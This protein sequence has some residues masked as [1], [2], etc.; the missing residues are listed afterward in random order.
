MPNGGA[1]EKELRVRLQCAHCM[2]LR[3]PAARYTIRARPSR[4]QVALQE[5]LFDEVKE[6]LNPKL[7]AEDINKKKVLFWQPTTTKT[8][9]GARSAPTHVTAW[10][11]CGPTC[12]TIS[13]S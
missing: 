13:P 2:M 1:D 8:K 9:G 7:P 10:P 12:T 5:A 4:V 11:R 3:E 6:N